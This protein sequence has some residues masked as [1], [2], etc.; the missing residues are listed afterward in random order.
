MYDSLC[1]YRC[2]CSQ[3]QFWVVALVYGVSFG[4]VNSWAGV[5]NISLSPHGISEQEAGWIGFYAIL[6][7]CVLCLMIARFA[8]TFAR[9]MKQFIIG[10]YLTSTIF[11]IIFALAA[12]KIIPSYTVIFYVTI[13][14]GM[15]SLTSAVPLIFELACELAFPT[16]EGTTNVVLTTICN[17]GGLLFLFVEMIPNI[18]YL[19]M[20]WTLVGALGLCLPMWVFLKENYNRLAVD[21]INP[22]MA[23]INTEIIVKPDQELQRVDVYM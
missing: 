3:K 23:A 4:V 22:S 15:T 18:G 21:E 1:V 6:A 7:G 9:V 8:D 19:W 14:G 17:I 12:I 11:F 10:L 20:N 2:P 13:I 16:G 5:L